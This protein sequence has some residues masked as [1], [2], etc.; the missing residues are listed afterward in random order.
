M[1]LLLI[2]SIAFFALTAF[3]ILF[4]IT[5][6]SRFD[7]DSFPNRERYFIGLVLWIVASI[8]AMFMSFPDYDEWF[9]PQVDIILQLV[10]V[11]FFI[12]GLF[13]IISTLIAFP[14]HLEYHRREISGR[15]D[16]LSVLES[17]RT[18]AGQ[19][20]PPTE[21]FALVLRELATYLSVPRGAVFLVN[22][23]RR[24]LYLVSQIGFDRDS[25]TRL[26]R[27]PLGKDVI[28]RAVQEQELYISGDVSASDS[29]SRRLL[30]GQ[31]ERTVSAVVIP[32]AVRDRTLGALLMLSDKSFGFEKR[33]RTLLMAAAE[34]LAGV[35]ENNRLT[36]ENQK[37]REMAESVKSRLDQLHAQLSRS[38]TQDSQ[39]ALDTSCKYLA[40]SCQAGAVRI[41]RLADGHLDTLTS[42]PAGAGLAADS[43]S[44]R[45]ALLNAMNQNRMV[46][47]NQEARGA[48]NTTYITRS[49]LF[50][51]LVSPR[52]VQYA[53]LVEGPAN[54][55]PMTEA[56]LGDVEAAAAMASLVLEARQLSASEQTHN[57]AIR[58][59]LNI[60]RIKR[61]SSLTL[62]CRQFITEI[63]RFMPSDISLMMSIEESRHGYRVIDGAN[64]NFDAAGE[65]IFAPGE[66]PVGK[67]AASGEILEA[68]GRSRVEKGW[69][70]IDRQNVDQLIRLM[71]ERGTPSYQLSIPIR[72]LD[73]VVAIL[74][75]F[76]FGSEAGSEPRQKGILLLA[77]QL[78][79]IKLTV[80]RMD[81]HTFAG[82]DPADIHQTALV[83]NRINN[84]LATIL[85]RAQLL[86]RQADLPGRARY[87]TDEIV[88]AAES[89][90]TSI[91]SLQEGMTALSGPET[92]TSNRPLHDL[93]K[94]L[95]QRHVTGNLYMFD[96]NQPVM[97][98]TRFDGS[99]PFE[100]ADPGI[101]AALNASLARFVGLLEEGDEVMLRTDLT[102][103]Y[104]YISLLRG[105]RE[106]HENFD[107][108]AVDFGD[109]D[110]LPEDLMPPDYIEKL[111]DNGG[112]VSFDRFGKRPT[113]L[114]FRFPAPE[115]KATPVEQPQQVVPKT[116]RILAIDDQQMI[117]DLLTG[118]CAS[119]GWHLTAIIDPRRALAV[120]EQEKFDIVMVDLAMGDVSGWDIARQIKDHRP[121]IPIILMTGWG[122]TVSPE[123]YRRAGI[124]FT[125]AKPFRI[126]QL[127]EII[128]KARI[129][130]ISP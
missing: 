97:L 50:C 86:S 23:S 73:S 27:F 24:E 96:D 18:I 95:A 17:I 36:R 94:Y 104:F 130:R 16:R 89:A 54:G 93:E 105:T 45:T 129:K 60:L 19:P 39:T 43:E 62:T 112:E 85:G 15:T 101:S 25:L 71:G 9:G 117:L 109:P 53:L 114:T 123:Q 121:D 4:S 111:T 82:I 41:I 32:L 31:S 83:L 90:A 26:E 7:A 102:G 106:R 5:R 125:L 76:G 8:P 69:D 30:L 107:P 120:F 44:Y 6:T 74:S 88:N 99:A 3:A 100:T 49:T 92:E 116:L 79:S 51:P 47:L 14:T 28:S 46:V 81:D 87:T 1:T 13:L 108:R 118:I 56:F 29:P 113:Y 37:L 66:G 119:L 42:F 72:V 34:A 64:L 75:I 78:L 10:L 126:E 65:C 63:A 128:N 67:A 61:E 12:I 122:I 70:D 35:I 80:G 98:Q 33:D 11:L 22:P 21:L 68:I 91:R 103:G 48:D 84:D 77:S 110:V 57:Q 2:G 55:L 38:V 20:Y 127:T 124:D 52:T 58:A 59:L 115:S 40:E